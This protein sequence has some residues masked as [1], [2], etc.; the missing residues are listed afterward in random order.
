MT[1]K[2][3]SASLVTRTLGGLLV[4]ALVATAPGTSNAGMGLEEYGP[5]AGFSIDPDQFTIGMFADWGELGRQTHLVTSADLGFGDHLFSFLLNGD[6]YYR[7]QTDKDFYPY[8]GGGLAIGYYNFDIPDI[9][10]PPGYTGPRVNVDDTATEVGL[11]L[12]GGI[13]KDLGGY[14]S[15][16][17]ELRLGISDVPDFKVTAQLGFF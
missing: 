13:T 1:T 12:V 10:Y 4:L 8:A 15:G 11:N 5:R 14:K 7:F 2:L 17:L 6:V 16:T 9:N 3:R